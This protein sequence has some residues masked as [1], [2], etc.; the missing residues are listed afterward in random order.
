MN[1]NKFN[2]SDMT[3][4]SSQSYPLISFNSIIDSDI[5]ILKY[6]MKNYLNPEIFDI[7]NLKSI[8]YN[9]L[10]IDIY[11]REYQNPL[12]Y[13][14]KENIDK[15]FLD[16]CYDELMKDHEYEI[17]NESVTTEIY[18]VIKYFIS[19]GI[20][21]TILYYSDAQKQVIKEDELLKNLSTISINTIQNK[22]FDQYFFKYISEANPITNLKLKSFYFSS[23][24][25]NLPEEA[26]LEKLYGNPTIEELTKSKRNIINFFDM[27]R[28]KLLRGET[29]K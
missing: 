2:V 8:S 29:N 25:L 21:S 15:K 23:C 6:V 10:L 1:N 18:N 22:D 13:I 26:T 19:G 4:Y 27:Y 24:G 20:N 28:I 5:G 7:E 17:L 9:K 3:G 11:K 16:D 12:Y 14:A